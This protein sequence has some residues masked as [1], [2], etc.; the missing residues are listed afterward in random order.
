MFDPPQGADGS[1]IIVLPGGA[2]NRLGPRESGPV[3]QRLNEAGVTAFVLRYRRRPYR[4]PTP[5]LDAARAVR[6]VRARAR[7]WQLDRTRAGV[8]G[9]S[10]GGHLSATISMTFDDGNPDSPDPIDHVSSRPDVSVLCY[11]VITFTGAAAHTGSRG[12]LLGRAAPQEMLELLSAQPAR[13]AADAA[14]LL[15]HTVAD[16]GVSV[17][18]SLLYAA[19]LRQHN[20][21]HAMRL[22][23]EGRHGVG[24]AQDEPVLRSW[25]G[26]LADWL[27]LHHF[28]RG[29]MAGA[30]APSTQQ[31]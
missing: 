27:A 24:L 26:I 14:D 10:A 20:V 3:A 22:Y 7:E 4:Y 8:L 17:E 9:F 6:T 18:N 30:I 15:F 11:P 2:Y 5:V 12:N 1:A 31:P 21:P 28:G 16:P 19:A 29:D 23:E 25:P 13:Y